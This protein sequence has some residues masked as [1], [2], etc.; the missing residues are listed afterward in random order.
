MEYF[1]KIKILE[2]ST[3]L[4]GPTVGMFFAELG[5]EVIKVENPLSK[6]DTTRGWKTPM[7]ERDQDLTA[8]FCSANWGK[9]SIALDLKQDEH[10]EVFTKLVKRSD[11]FIINTKPGDDKKL[12]VDYETI[13]K[14]NENII[15]AHIT[16]YGLDDSR[17]AFDAAIQA[18]S[19]FMSINGTEESGP[20]KMPVALIDILAAHQIKDAILLAI[21]KNSD[22][23]KISKGS[24]INC[25]LLQAGI[26]SLANQATNYFHNR[27][28]MKKEY[29]GNEEKIKEC[30]PVRTGSDH[31]NIFP[32]GTLF[33]TK[34]A[35]KN[36][37]LVIGT[38]EQFRVFYKLY[39]S[40]T[41]PKN[42]IEFEEIETNEQ[43][44]IQRNKLKQFIGEVLKK[45]NSDE[46]INELNKNKIPAAVVL[47][48]K[49]VFEQKQA[50]EILLEKDQIFGLRTFVSNMSDVDK[51]ELNKPPR[52]NEN[53]KDILVNIL[54]YNDKDAN[55]IMKGI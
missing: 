44:V 1:E 45:K 5:A 28:I 55:K 31:P 17:P 35:D 14:Y 26:S 39:L 12:K 18:Y 27:E 10:Y 16:G 43:R 47:N 13:K 37:M 6:G 34:D 19:G 9:K 22:Q 50:K 41:D 23:G 21:I 53:G 54:K 7:E 24:Y 46:L 15:Y 30:I 49:E 51:V 40:N 8:Y 36:I 20:V 48:I 38:D 33:K 32:Y 42:R 29:E 3:I 25:S 2:F 52:F 11:I 4:A